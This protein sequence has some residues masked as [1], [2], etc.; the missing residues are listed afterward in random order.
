MNIDPVVLS[1]TEKQ[2]WEQKVETLK[3]GKSG[4]AMRG[5]ST[6]PSSSQSGDVTITSREISSLLSGQ[7]FGNSVFSISFQDDRIQIAANIPVP[8]DI[9]QSLNL[10]LGSFQSIASMF[11]STEV[12]PVNASARIN[13][14]DGKVFLQLLSADL[15]GLPLSA[16]AGSTWDG[17]QELDIVNAFGDQ[18]PVLKSVLGS[19]NSL[20]FDNQGLH[21]S[22]R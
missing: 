12:V 19:L 4:I 15:M 2:V 3:R 13:L 18:A 10:Q 11:V 14:K 9:T 7:E 21:L 20:Q 16:V 1:S 22:P 8:P 17:W 6:S 5:K